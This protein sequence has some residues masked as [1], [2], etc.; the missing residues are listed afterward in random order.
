ME[1]KKHNTDTLVLGSS[2]PLRLQTLPPTAQSIFPFLP[3]VILRQPEDSSS[4]DNDTIATD[5]T[6]P[7]TTFEET[8]AQ[9]PQSNVV[10]PDTTETIDNT[11]TTDS[12][13][14]PRSDE[15]VPTFTFTESKDGS[16]ADK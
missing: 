11:D 4:F 1:N 10:P 6:E 7:I 5:P 14:P 9:S 12:P 2:A 13:P 16:G 3:A 8:T 15:E